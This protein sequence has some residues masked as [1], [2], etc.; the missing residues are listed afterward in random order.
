VAGA[1]SLRMREVY[2]D[3]AAGRV[4]EFDHWLSYVND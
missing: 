3:V 2:L 1:F 4:P